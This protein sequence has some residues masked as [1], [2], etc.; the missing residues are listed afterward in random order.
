MRPVFPLLL[1]LAGSSGFGAPARPEVKASETPAAPP[2]I[3]PGV[4]DEYPGETP[5]AKPPMRLTEKE[6]ADLRAQVAASAEKLAAAF[7]ALLPLESAVPVVP[8]GRNSGPPPPLS[9]AA[10]ALLKARQQVDELGRLTSNQ[11]RRLSEQE[12]LPPPLPKGDTHE[13]S[14][15]TLPRASARTETQLAVRILLIRNNLALVELPVGATVQPGAE[16][17]LSRDLV[18][19]GRGMVL[20]S[21]AGRCVVQ[22]AGFTPAT[23]PGDGF[24]LTVTQKQ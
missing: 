24:A 1:L 18:Q 21:A 6:L 4:A 15:L 3:T 8:P 23:K 12:N 14:P 20:Q 7:A 9:P 11:L 5:A 13:P 10:S 22:A 17:I 16:A 19:S 2:M